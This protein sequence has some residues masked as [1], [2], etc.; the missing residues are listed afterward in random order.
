MEGIPTNFTFAP[1]IEYAPPPVVVNNSNQ[2]SHLIFG[3]GTQMGGVAGTVIWFGSVA[4][5][6]YLWAIF[7]AESIFFI[8]SGF[9]ILATAKNFIH[10]LVFPFVAIP[11]ELY[12]LFYRYIYCPL[13]HFIRNLSI[14][15][16]VKEA[17]ATTTKQKAETDFEKAWQA[18]K[19]PGL[20]P[21]DPRV[22]ELNAY[23]A[24]YK[25]PKYCPAGGGCM[26]DNRTVAPSIWT[27]EYWF[28]KGAKESTAPLT[29]NCSKPK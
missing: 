12:V 10:L 28:C 23:E 5:W 4:L 17:S 7:T 8:R 19:L 13:D 21:D 11:M 3:R 29:Y 16:D 25:P 9:D 18:G 27:M 14:V 26:P 6:A 24:V 2:P 22:S 1:V 15:K 20:N